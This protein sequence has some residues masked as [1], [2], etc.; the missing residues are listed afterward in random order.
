MRDVFGLMAG[1]GSVWT[2]GRKW[3][4]KERLGGGAMGVDLTGAARIG[5]A[6]V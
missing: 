6:R 2:G 1:E 5:E 4:E 3:R